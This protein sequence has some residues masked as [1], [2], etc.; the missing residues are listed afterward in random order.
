MAETK[1]SKNVVNSETRTKLSKSG[2]S[3]YNAIAYPLV[4][5]YLHQL[6][7]PDA[8]VQL[9]TPHLRD[10]RAQEP[11]LTCEQYKHR[12]TDYTRLPKLL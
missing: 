7:G 3:Y 2:I 9:Q 12:N 8:T 1:P 6:I 10:T 5:T 4:L 11:M